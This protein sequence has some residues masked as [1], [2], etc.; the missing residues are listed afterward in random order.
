[1]GQFPDVVGI[2][3]AEGSLKMPVCA[4][5]HEQLLCPL[6]R[7]R[8]DSGVNRTVHQALPC[9]GAGAGVAKSVSGTQK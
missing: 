6:S 7:D 4:G 5:L 1:M 9:H 2:A 8:S 3:A